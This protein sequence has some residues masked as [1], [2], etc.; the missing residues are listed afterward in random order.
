MQ[1]PMSRIRLGL[2]GAAP[3]RAF[4][5]GAAAA[6]ATLLSV[7]VPRIGP[8]VIAIFTMSAAAILAAQDL[9]KPGA[10]D[11]AKVF[12]LR[13]E[14]AFAAWILIACA[15]SV[16]PLNSFYEAI[17][18]SVLIVHAL[19]L[20]TVI[21]RI[22][23]KDIAAIARGFL[24]GFILAGLFVCYE[25]WMR[26][27]IVRLVLTYFPD[28]ER[29]LD[30]HG[31]IVN[32]KVLRMTGGVST[33]SAAV[34]SLLLSSAVLAARLYTEGRVRW[35]LY[36]SI[37][38]FSVVVMLHPNAESQSAQLMTAVA[39][40]A[41][42]MAYAAPRASYWIWSLAFAALLFLVIPLALALFAAD[43]HKNPSLF[44]SG[45]A[46]VIIW[47]FTAQRYLEKPIL[48]VG[49]NSTRHLDEERIRQRLVKRPK[50]FVVAPQTRAHPHNIYLQIWYEL[51]IPGV[52][53]FAALGFALLR[54]L[55]LM[56]AR[57]YPMGIT[58]AAVCMTIL[59]PTY[60]LWQN[61]FQC[62][63]V[64][65]ILALVLFAAPD[66]KR[67]TENPQPA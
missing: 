11:R 43:V 46:R 18:L 16:T 12:F 44:A 39:I 32:G 20:A 53:A 67:S 26:Q 57:S 27:A 33:R 47:D 24:V 14:M 62:A 52:L 9:R 59:V 64:T 61:W 48:G 55:Q 29:G 38:V 56:G 31:T 19:F 37:L 17:F 4:L 15:W 10:L 3:S 8:L 54:K 63:I 30:K 42:A 7:M 35:A 25:I 2:P 50:D 60:G 41:L 40:L 23:V 21:D 58:H 28:L 5:L 66:I 6:I 49:T 22:D 13:P 45:R 36:A 34:F 51:G 1:Q 65:S